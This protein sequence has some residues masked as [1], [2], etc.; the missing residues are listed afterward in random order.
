MSTSKIQAFFSFRTVSTTAVASLFYLAIFT[1][2]YVTQY[3]PS[4]PSLQSQYALGLSV[5]HAYRDLH[6]VSCPVILCAALN[7]RIM[8]FNRSQNALTLTTPVK[9]ILSAISSSGDYGR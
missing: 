9:T 1:S 5:E 7:R 4:V 2:L 3:G 8:S 6:L